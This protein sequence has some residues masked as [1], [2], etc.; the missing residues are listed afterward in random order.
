MCPR[1]EIKEFGLKMFLSLWGILLQVK[2]L[3]LPYLRYYYLYVQAILIY[4]AKCAEKINNYFL[5]MQLYK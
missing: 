1:D 4:A 2:Q 3:F 5:A